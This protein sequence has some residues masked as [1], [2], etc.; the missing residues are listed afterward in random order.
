MTLC[1]GA[2]AP[3]EPFV[4]AGIWIDAGGIP[5]KG[6]GKNAERH[7]FKAVFREFPGSFRFRGVFCR[8]F[9]PMPFPGMPFGPFQGMDKRA[10]KLRIA[11][12]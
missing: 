6:I 1:K 2:L 9:L 10:P 7:E 11:I 3:K 8:V 4:S 12:R 5:T